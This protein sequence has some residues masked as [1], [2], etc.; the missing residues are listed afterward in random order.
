MNIF[1]KGTAEYLPASPQGR[2]PD[3]TSESS[4][5]LPLFVF[6]TQH[7]H[8]LLHALSMSTVFFMFIMSMLISFNPLM[9]KNR[10]MFTIQSKGVTD[11]LALHWITKFDFPPHFLEGLMHSFPIMYNTMGSKLDGLARRG[12]FL[13]K[14]TFEMAV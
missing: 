7:L 14:I 5:F 4:V 12:H 2:F 11:I 1:G 13:Q 3:T 10:L 6:F 8:G 9:T